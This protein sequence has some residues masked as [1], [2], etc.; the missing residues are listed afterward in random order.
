MNYSVVIRTVGTAGEKYQRLL[1]SIHSQTIKPAEILVVLPEGYPLPPERLGYETFIYSE[2]GMVVQ[3]IYG[4]RQAKS[5]YV[6]FLDDDLEF[7]PTFVEEMYA[8]ILKGLCEVTIPV[9]LEMLPPKRGIRKLIPMISLSACPTVIHKKDMYTKVLKSGGWSYNNFEGKTVAKYLRCETA[10][11]ACC[12]CR[13]KDFL[14]IHFEE[15]M[16]LQDV[17]YALWE[18]QV[19]FYKMHLS[20]KRIMCVT[21]VDFTHL[22]AGGSSPDRAKLAAHAGARNKKIFWYKFIYKKQKNTFGRIS[23]R[24]M[25]GYSVLA[26]SCISGLHALLSPAKREEFRAYRQGLRDGKAYVKENFKK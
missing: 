15:E 18:D 6:L 14:D 17:K 25:Y 9:F 8:P 10:A 22:D 4:G 23:A 1:D 21:D 11:G 7:S 13:R 16:W 2:K 12:F 26:S 20:G 3:R 5:E 19:M 24:L